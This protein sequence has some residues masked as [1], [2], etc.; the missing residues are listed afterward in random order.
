MKS[1][2][3]VWIETSLDGA[4]RRDRLGHGLIGRIGVAA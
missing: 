3:L 1:F 2:C 4:A